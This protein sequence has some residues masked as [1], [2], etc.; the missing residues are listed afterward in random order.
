MMMIVVGRVKGRRRD[1]NEKKE[2]KKRPGQN[3]RGG[4]IRSC[5]PDQRKKREVK[6]ARRR[7]EE[8]LR[9]FSVF[10]VLVSNLASRDRTIG[11]VDFG[12]MSISAH[13]NI[14]GI[15]DIG[16]RMDFDLVTP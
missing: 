10:V 9:S 4:V 8:R 16:I 12:F 11:R 7:R 15:V 6:S 5:V 2:E 14:N 1:G 3:S 13:L